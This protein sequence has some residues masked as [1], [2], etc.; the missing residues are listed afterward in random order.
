VSAFYIRA[1]RAACDVHF[2]GNYAQRRGGLKAWS[3]VA[4]KVR[5]NWPV[6]T[7]A[8]CERLGARRL[9]GVFRCA[10]HARRVRYIHSLI[11]TEAGRITD[12]RA[13]NH[14]HDV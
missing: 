9:G 14:V 1:V 10:T 2:S 3:A 12:C 6:L 7:K 11:E 5:G 8:G 13:C 4:E